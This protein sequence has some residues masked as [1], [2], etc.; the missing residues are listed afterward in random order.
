MARVGGQLGNQ[1]LWNLSALMSTE[2]AP[3]AKK[4]IGTPQG[5]T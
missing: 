3:G 5:G 1:N 4:T 2:K